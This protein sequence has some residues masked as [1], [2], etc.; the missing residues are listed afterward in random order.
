MKK[1]L[2]TLGIFCIVITSLHAQSSLVQ[3]E[4]IDA[5]GNPTGIASSWDILPSGGYVYFLFRQT[6]NIT[7][8]LWYLYIDKDYDNTGTYAPYETI[9]LTPETIKNWFVYDYFYKEAGKYRAMIMK[10]GQEL[11]STYFQIN[12]AGGTTTSTT[13]VDTYYYESSNI[14]FCKSV[15][16]EG[17]LTGVS[18]QFTRDASGNATV[19]IY[20][21]NSEKPLKTNTL[22]V[23]I[24]EVGTSSV[25]F[26]SETL[27]IQ[28]TWDWV[29]FEY[30]FNKPGTYTMHVITGGNIFVNNSPYVIIK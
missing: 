1:L 12:M 9:S 20:L 14:L 22:Y 28:E 29:K 16:A 25:L 27:S 17:R 11:A 24:Y 3:C 26:D 6:Y 7:S 13:G 2:F 21:S 18:N 30:T 19:T 10:D 15:D 5:Y 23:D 8:G 4:S